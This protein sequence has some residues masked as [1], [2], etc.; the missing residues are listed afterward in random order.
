MATTRF[1]AAAL[2]EPGTRRR[3]PTRPRRRV[4]GHTTHAEC[5]VAELAPGPA[6][7]AGLRR[8][9]GGVLRAG[10]SHDAC[11]VDG[12]GVATR[13]GPDVGHGQR[14]WQ[15]RPAH[16][17]DVRLRSAALSGHQRTRHWLSADPPLAISRHSPVAARRKC[18]VSEHE[19]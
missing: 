5:M 1:T 13:P 19:L 14:T 2:T 4:E 8:G 6:H 15:A 12:S 3:A 10:P 16:A 18:G 9:P 11:C 7:A 17:R